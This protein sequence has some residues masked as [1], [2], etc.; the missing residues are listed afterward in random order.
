MG[1]IT[2]KSSVT[3]RVPSAE[4]TMQFLTHYPLSTLEADRAAFNAQKDTP[5][6]KM[7]FYSYIFNLEYDKLRS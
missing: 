1:A 5:G 3:I 2:P 6:G 4:A 7:T